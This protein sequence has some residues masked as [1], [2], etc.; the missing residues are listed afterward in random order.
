MSLIIGTFELGFIYAIMAVGIFVS[1]RILNVPDLTVDGSFITGSACA[2]ALTVMGHPY[3]G[4][5]AAIGAGFLAGMCTG[6][7]H[8]KLKIQP[9]LAGILTMT[10][11][12]TIN[13]RI[14]GKKPNV[15]IRNVDNI[16]TAFEGIL[17]QPV[18][19]L[20]ISGLILAI[21]A[22]ALYFFLKTQLGMSLRATGDN[23]EMVRA[24]S[25]NSDSMKILGLGIANAYVALSGAVVVSYQNF[26][27][28]NGGIGMMVMGLASIIIGETIF[29]RKGIFRSLMAAIVGAI[30]YRGILTIALQC[31]LQAVDY[32]LFYAVI[33]VIA[34]MLPS[35]KKLLM[36]RKKNA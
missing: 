13:L 6:I 12:Y 4:L 10:A 24:S 19:K 16:Y 20:V 2:A 35:I 28:A 30:I 27:D 1:F 29:G 9:I 11:L 5:L 17:P 36:R 31:G 21:A 25:I 8:T 3:L 26:A 15:S 32:K 33:V 18:L 14:M 7:L 34:I 23:E 22:A